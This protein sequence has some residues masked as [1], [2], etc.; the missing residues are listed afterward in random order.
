MDPYILGGI[1]LAEGS[2]AVGGGDL[3]RKHVVDGQQRIVTLCLL[4]AAARERLGS[5]AGADSEYADMAEQL[6]HALKTVGGDWVAGTG[7]GKAGRQTV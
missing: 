1:N 6:G 7:A 5:G 3:K 2:V 4:F